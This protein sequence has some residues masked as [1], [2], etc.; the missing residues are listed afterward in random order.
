LLDRPLRRGAFDD[1]LGGAAVRR[2]L[3]NNEL[4]QVIGEDPLEVALVDD[5]IYRHIQKI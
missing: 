2:E 1:W 4:E 3:L 5:I